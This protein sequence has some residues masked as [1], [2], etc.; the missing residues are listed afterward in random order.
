M[1]SFRL[2]VPLLALLFIVFGASVP[3]SGTASGQEA[4]KEK[5]VRKFNAEQMAQIDAWGQD[6]NR[7]GWRHD[8]SGQ[9]VGRYFGIIKL[10]LLNILF[11]GWVAT[12]SWINND[13]QQTIDLNRTF[14]NWLSLLIF[15]LTFFISLFI[16]I[17][18]AVLPI[19]LLA[20]LVPVFVYVHHRN[21]G[22]LKADKVMTPDHLAFLMKRMLRMNVAPKKAVYET[23]SPIQLF[24]W[25]K[26]TT[27][28]IRKG[29]G[30]AARNQPGY[31]HAR[32]MIYQTIQR[33]AICIRIE[34][35]TSECRFFLFI[36]GVWH[37]VTDLFTVKGRAQ[38]TSEDAAPLCAVLKILSGCRPEESVKRQEGEFQALYGVKK[39][40]EATVI[41]QGKSGVEEI[42]I[43]FQ[44][45]SLTFHTLEELG[46]NDSRAESVKKLLN[47][48]K[49]LVILSAAPG[50]GLRTMTNVAFNVA[51]RF[52]RDF[53]TVEDIN[54]PYM[55]IENIQLNTYDS[56][57]KETP[58]TILP[59]VFFR[60][61]KVLLLRDLVNTETLQLCCEEIANNRLII[62]TF[63]GR[64]SV[65]TILRMLKTGIAP[66]LLADSLAVVLTQRLVRR[67]CPACKEA[68]PANPQ[69]LRRLGL[70]ATIETLYRKRVH[71]A[72]ERG[73]KDD[74]V[75][76]EKCREIGYWGRAGIYDGIVIND[77]IRQ[78]MTTKP[79]AEALR[80]A[81]VKA[82]CRGYLYDGAQLIADGITSFEELARVMKE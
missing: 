68:I 50:Q 27:E 51:D 64:D 38:F 79:T 69:V 46:M 80:Q 17:F 67:L 61:P 8:A 11:W 20:W 78:I 37:Q 36:D 2:A 15:P 70:P 22:R 35:T 6:A 28:Q 25:G 30:I 39:K 55:P 19:A 24:G 44:F 40:L 7:N 9:G 5:S 3:L 47:I 10:V 58:M 75:P 32:E 71:A 60:E 23:G 41:S 56:S 54:K 26:H 57:K 48:D 72:P 43:Q 31:N 76:C 34:R 53:S 4:E 18:F 49:G 65:D 33:G 59:D 1:K 73:Q 52:T 63:R 82:K 77:E 29:R 81:A 62:T 16:P 12:S 45:R 42:L 66:K 13:T 74:Y 21:I 14:W